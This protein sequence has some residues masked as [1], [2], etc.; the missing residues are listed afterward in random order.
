MRKVGC[1]VGVLVVILISSC[2][3]RRN[4]ESEALLTPGQ[5]FL[6][7]DENTSLNSLPKSKALS[8]QLKSLKAEY[9][10]NKSNIAVINRLVD[11]LFLLKKNKEAIAYGKQILVTDPNNMKVRLKIAHAAVRQR[12]YPYAEFVLSQT[13]CSKDTNCSNLLGVIAYNKGKIKEALEYFKRALTLST[14]NISASLN[15]ALLYMEF[16]KFDDALAEVRSILKQ[17]P[18]DKNAKLIL[19]VLLVLQ[20]KLDKAEDVLEDLYVKNKTNPVVL[21]NLSANAL[22]MR[23][24]NRALK[25]INRTL[26]F[27]PRYTFSID[28]S[29]KLKEEVV[30][31]KKAGG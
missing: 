29:I 17:S 27:A 9:A 24:Y 26:K 10:N 7:T 6:I 3:S 14:K 4:I 23:D 8:E 16:Y 13:P 31:K 22:K 18:R 20:R 11:T 30:L 1:Y 12:K 19:A 15:L 5:P 21:H 25:L 28:K 2:M